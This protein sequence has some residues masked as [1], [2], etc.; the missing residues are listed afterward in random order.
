MYSYI[1]FVHVVSALFFGCFLTFPLVIHTRT[2]NVSI[3]NLKTI[4]AFIRFGHYALILL[5][6]SGGW[7]VM[8]YSSYPSTAWV[9]ISI[10]LLIL[11]GGL[12]GMVQKNIKQIIVAKDFEKAL[13]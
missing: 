1:L 6:V 10:M 7:M 4:L 3:T 11:I 9:V 13:L 8:G 5:I 2:N 12:I